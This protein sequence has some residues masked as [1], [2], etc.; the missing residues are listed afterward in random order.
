MIGLFGE[1]AK[2]IERIIAKSLYEK[3]NLKFEWQEDLSLV[4]YV[5]KVRKN[6]SRAITIRRTVS[7]EKPI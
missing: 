2:V 1:G 3:L 5:E 4:E 6:S 7:V